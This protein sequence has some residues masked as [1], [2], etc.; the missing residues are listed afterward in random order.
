MDSFK[1]FSERIQFLFCFIIK[2]YD[3]IIKSS[4]PNKLDK[5][6]INIKH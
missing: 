6:L 1:M 3:Q 2:N 4:M 5:Y